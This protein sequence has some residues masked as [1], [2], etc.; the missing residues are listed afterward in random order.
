ML[1]C[2][3]RTNKDK[4]AVSELIKFILM[5]TASTATGGGL[6]IDF[7]GVA[8]TKRSTKCAIGFASA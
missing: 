7:G 4:A 2:G 8:L 5:L 3:R 1:E 6:D